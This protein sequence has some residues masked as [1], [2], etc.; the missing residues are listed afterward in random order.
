[1]CY[2]GNPQLLRCAD[3][4]HWHQET[5]QC[6]YPE[7]VNCEINALPK[8]PED[9]VHFFPH[10]HRCTQ[11]ISCFYGKQTIVNC[12]FNEHWDI[13]QNKCIAQNLAT[14]ILD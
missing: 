6:D 11:Y 3:D 8:C 1:M 9:G 13:I 4:M 12:P 5:L 14:C 7:N 10:P 2:K